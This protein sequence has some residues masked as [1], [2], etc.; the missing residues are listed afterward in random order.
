[1]FKKILAVALAIVMVMAMA[2]VAVSAAEVSNSAGAE[3]SNSA[4]ADTSSE[5]TGT[6]GVIYF[7]AQ[8][9]NNVTQVYCHLWKTGGDPF[10][11]WKQPQQKCTNV[12]GALWSYDLSA[13]DASTDLPGGLKANEDY[14]VIFHADTGVQT[15]DTTFGTPCIGD[16]LSITGNQIE[17]PMDSEKTGYEAVWSKNSANY[18]P[19]FAISSIGSFLGKN[20]CPNET[21]AE[22]MGNWLINYSTSMNCVPKDVVTAAL[23]KLGIDSEAEVEE[24]YTYLSGKSASELG[25]SDMPTMV[26]LLEDGY[27]AAYGTSITV[28]GQVASGG[29]S[30]TTPGGSNSGGSTSDGSTSGGSTSGGSTSSSG[31]TGTSSTTTSAD[32]TVTVTKPDGTVTITKPDGTV[33]T[34]T[35]TGTTV[36]GTTT[37]TNVSGVGADGQNDTILFV[38]A[39]IMLVAAGAFVVTRKR[40]EV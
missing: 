22:V 38:L 14:C 35:T 4:G 40:T 34:T 18:G 6:S 25:L 10:F 33:T 23:P 31:T 13:L 32:G 7:N 26:G 24:V 3:V 16:R 12:S 21:S 30:E 2:A 37:S 9:W 1:M 5:A 39:A 8:G 29:G 28:D 27:A 19:H 17:N 15:Y 20:L 36:G 11:G